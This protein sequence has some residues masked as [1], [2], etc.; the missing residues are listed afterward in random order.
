M[1]SFEFSTREYNKKSGHDSFFDLSKSILNDTVLSNSVV[2]NAISNFLDIK[3]E[4]KSKHK[5]H[6][7][8]YHSQVK[9]S[10]KNIK[11]QKSN[12]SS[13]SLIKNNNNNNK[14][15]NSNFNI[16]N[17]SKN[18]MAKNTNHNNLLSMEY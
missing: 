18:S 13:K 6:K 15:K 7:D 14:N 4:D 2:I 11:M 12:K 5:N 3:A 17:L 1:K 9:V 8:L 16:S 10:S